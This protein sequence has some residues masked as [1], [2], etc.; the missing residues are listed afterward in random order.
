MVAR[1]NWSEDLAVRKPGTMADPLN[2]TAPTTQS[3]ALPMAWKSEG[4]SGWK[5]DGKRTL[6]VARVN[7]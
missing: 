3:V 6:E 4:W 5:L 2:L 7:P 1:M